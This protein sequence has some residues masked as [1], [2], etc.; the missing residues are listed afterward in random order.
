MYCI[1]KE[2]SDKHQLSS[3][4]VCNFVLLLLELTDAVQK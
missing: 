4:V 3:E 2:A 1:F